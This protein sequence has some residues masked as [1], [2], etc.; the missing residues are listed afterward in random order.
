MILVSCCGDWLVRSF[1]VIPHGFLLAP[2][3]LSALALPFVIARLTRNRLREVDPRYLA[4]FIML[5]SHLTAGFLMNAVPPGVVVSGIR[6]YLKVMPFFLIPLLWPQ[7]VRQLHVQLTLLTLIS[8]IQLP[9]AY[10]QRMAGVVKG[11][12]TG[13]RTV[14][15]LNISSNLSVFICCVAAVALAMYLRGRLKLQWLVLF[16]AFTLPA[17]MINETKGTL[18]LA[19]LAFL[20]P[21]FLAP[22]K[23]GMAAVVKRNLLA[24]FLISGFV[25]AFIPI[26]DSFVQARWH[27]GIVDFLS[28]KNRVAGYL[29]KNADLGS[30]GIGRIDSMILPFVASKHD[31]V[32]QAFGLG[33]GNVSR[34]SLGP[35][36]TGAYYTRYG[37]LTGPSASVFFWEIGWLGVVWVL[38]F[39][40]FI[41]RDAMVAR[42]APGIEGGLALGWLGV[43]GLMGL[44]L[45]YTKSVFTS[46][47]GYLYFFY[48]GVVAATAMRLRS[49]VAS[50]IAASRATAAVGPVSVGYRPNSPALTAS[51]KG[52]GGNASPR[53]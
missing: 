26:Y 5:I 36:Y 23:G 41:F 7:T 22:S 47:M 8:L 17:T 1:P 21:S 10:K 19:P 40:F 31:P 20:I 49:R 30:Q 46:Q 15:T 14:G 33:A 52:A 45:F 39:M 44:G 29:S 38:L 37:D 12:M 18:V 6:V 13:D 3:T 34:S 28:D 24:L 2:E 27:S 32:Q 53:H 43:T 9:I 4:I 16:L 42:H 50:R 11:S 48:S 51:A 35:S 25:A